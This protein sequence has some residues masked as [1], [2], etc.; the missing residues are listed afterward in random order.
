MLDQHQRERLLDSLDLPPAGRRIVL[1]AVLH[2]PVRKVTSKGG[3]NVISIYQS[4]KMQRECGTESRHLEFPAA[5]RHEHDPAVLEYYHQPCRLKFEVIDDSGEIHQIDHIPDLMVITADGVILEEWKSEAAL[6][7]LARKKPWRYQCDADGQWRSPPIEQWLAA[8]GITYRFC[9]DA[10]ISPRRI[11][12]TLFLEDY[13]HPAAE[14]C[15]IDVTV[16]V[17]QALAEDAAL[18]LAELYERAE[19]RPD[20]AFKLIADGLLVAEIDGALLSEPNRCRV[21]RDLAVRDFENARSVGTGLAPISGVVDIRPGARIRYNHQPYTVT[22]VGS[23]K[24][25]LTSENGIRS[26]IELSLLD[27]LAGNGHLVMET[28]VEGRAPRES[29]ADFTEDEL[30][31]A[32][33]RNTSLQNITSPNRT[34]RRHLKAF[35]VAKLT[36]IDELVALVP[37]FRARGNRTPRLSAEQEEAM[38]QVIR[39]AHLSNRAQNKKACHNVLRALCRERGIDAP[40]YPTLIE[41]INALP[42]ILADRAR[43]GK[44]VAYQNAEFVPWL[45]F[46][47]PIHGVRPFQIVHM[48]HTQ[49]DIELVSIR[50]GK[51]LGRPWLSLAVDAFTRRIVGLYLSFDPPSYRSNMML[52]RDI[53]RRF[54]R[55]P[56]MIVVDNGADFRSENFSLFARLMSIHLRFRPAGHARHGAVLERLFGSLNTEYIHNLAGNTKATKIVRQTTGKFLPSRLAEW[57]LEA[58]YYGVEYW[59][60]VYYDQN[61]HS[62]LDLSP[63][64]AFDRGM[65]AS[66]TRPHRIVTLTRDFLILTCPMVGRQGTRTVDRQRGVKVNDRFYYWC[67]EMANPQVAGKKIPVRYDP[68]NASTVYVQIDKRWQPAICKSL[69]AL[70]AMTETE[71]V[72]LSEEFTTTHPRITNDELSVQRLSEFLRTFTPDGALAVQLQRQ[73]E[74]RH[75]YHHL[76]L[77]SVSPAETHLRLEQLSSVSNDPPS[78]L[79]QPASVSRFVPTPSP[80]DQSQIDDLT[81]FDTF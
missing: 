11:E 30:R 1:D 31:V 28:E 3:G 34:Q 78:I 53:V 76:G 80:G 71:R 70:G 42:Q 74:N 79:P 2:S 57:N 64:E 38:A 61:V 46:D 47:T 60:T 56:Q 13:L 21:F 25:I 55:L 59:A 68:W 26:E 67:P 77:A 22:L 10:Q 32:L 50:T 44:R 72:V 4:R 17:Q 81:D 48:D 73:E 45:K 63:M 27:D 36:G 8:K 24:I 69:A 66:G 40:S 52:L 62:A 65:A 35:A 23:Q 14:A 41:R 18:Y 5:V 39:E 20:D 37:R 6:Q 43:H 29:C 75:L 19:C 54:G 12:N 15:P 33:S 51:N 16:R 9:T 58:L 49:L 7:G